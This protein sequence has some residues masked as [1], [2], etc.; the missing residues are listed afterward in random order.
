MVGGEGEALAASGCVTSE[1]VDGA[2]GTS[3][4]KGED[5]LLVGIGGVVG[6]G[7]GGTLVV[8]GLSGWWGNSV[9]AEAPPMGEVEGLLMEEVFSTLPPL[10]C[11]SISAFSSSVIVVPVGQRS[12][13]S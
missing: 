10:I 8:V 9:G 12:Y 1:V 4:G 13:L 3:G 2:R 7:A 5:G 11:F 6:C